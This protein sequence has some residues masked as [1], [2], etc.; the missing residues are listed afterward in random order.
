[1]NLKIT[2]QIYNRKVECD[3]TIRKN[4]PL[5]LFATL[6]KLSLFHHS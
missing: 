3:E 5:S 2:S 6:G 1:M 4:R